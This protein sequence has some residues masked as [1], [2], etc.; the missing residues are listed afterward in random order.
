MSN[1]RAPRPDEIP[2]LRQLWQEA[3]GDTEEYLDLYFTAA[4]APERC[5][6]LDQNGIAAAAHWMDCR[7]EDRKLAYVY[8][9]AV[10]KDLQGQGLGTDLM[11]ALHHHL[12]NLNYDL[13]LLVP[14]DEGLRSYYRRLGYETLSHQDRF[15]AT[16]G[17]AVSMTRLNRETYARLR[18]DFLG[19]WGVIQEGPSLALLEGMAEFYRGD[20]FLAALAPGEGI[21]P[22][23]LGDRSAAPGITAAMG[24][25][26]CAFRTPGHAV[27]YA[28]GLALNGPPPHSLYFGFGFD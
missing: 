26:T 28:M 15:T 17:T 24:L 14:G 3:F 10:R 23:L 11:K 20:G 22:E 19:Q 25:N 13:I 12:E 2:T 1:F 4:F 27:P 21:C 5:L 9:V 6:V 7:V 8:A 16:A 18:R